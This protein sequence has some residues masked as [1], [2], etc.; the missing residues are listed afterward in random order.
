MYSSMIYFIHIK[1]R[2]YMSWKRFD[3]V[4]PEVNENIFALNAAQLWWGIYNPETSDGSVPFIPIYWIE[5]PVFTEEE[6]AFSSIKPVELEKE[7]IVVAEQEI[8]E[9]FLKS[10]PSPP[11]FPSFKQMREDGQK[12]AQRSGQTVKESRGTSKK[13]RKK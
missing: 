8:T 12:N 7:L 13:S 9:E 11:Q 6:I 4:R 10:G 2:I 3:E 5:R 1:K